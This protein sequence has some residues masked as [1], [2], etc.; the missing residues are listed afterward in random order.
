MMK[1]LEKFL[2]DGVEY[3]YNPETEYIKGGHAY[4]KICHEQKDGKVMDFLDRKW[5]L[6][7]EYNCDRER[8]KK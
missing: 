5:I 2:I 3:S 8:A 6:K 4:C 7:N 1:E